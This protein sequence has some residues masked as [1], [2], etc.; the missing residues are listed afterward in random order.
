MESLVRARFEIL[1][2]NKRIGVSDEVFAKLSADAHLALSAAL[3]KVTLKDHDV[4]A[5]VALVTNGPLLQHDASALVMTLNAKLDEAPANVG[6]KCI[7][8]DCTSL[9]NFFAHRE[10]SLFGSA[11]ADLDAKLDLAVNRACALGVRHP[12][13]KSFAAMAAVVVHRAELS[14]QTA[15]GVVNE[16]KKRFRSKTRKLAPPPIAFVELPKTWEQY[17]S[18][19]P[20]L[21]ACLFSDSDQPVAPPIAVG[22]LELLTRLVPCRSTRAGCENAARYDYHSDRSRR[23]LLDEPAWS[24]L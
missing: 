14:Q 13:E 24:L 16:L 15:L 4:A 3:T 7:L 1:L 8:Q 17:K 22:D 20:V 11:L 21:G 10:W 5:L 19:R 9:Y 2:C 23:S 12:S 6:N 18:Q